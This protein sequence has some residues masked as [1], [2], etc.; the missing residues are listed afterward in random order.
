MGL[1]PVFCKKGLT[2]SAF[3]TRGMYDIT[4]MK[5]AEGTG[6]YRKALEYSK[7]YA[8][9]LDSIYKEK[10]ENKMMEMQRKY[11]LTQ[12]KI[13]SDRL[14]IKSQHNSIITLGSYWHAAH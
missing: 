6:N 14:K 4:M 13:E 9:M 5:W 11:D 3:V 1:S 8:E 7:H 10:T 12:A 2:D